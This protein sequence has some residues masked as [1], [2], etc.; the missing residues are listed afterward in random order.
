MNIAEIVMPG[1]VPGIHVL[2]A[3]WTGVDGR[4]KPSHDAAETDGAHSHISYA[5]ALPLAGRGLEMTAAS[6][7][8]IASAAT[9]S[10]TY[11]RRQ[12]G[13]L[14]YARN[15]GDRASV[16]PLN[17]VAETTPRTPYTSDREWLRASI[18]TSP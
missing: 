6:S 10:R 14:R 18:L 13:L 9:Q 16:P 15:D 5:I 7:S 1:L 17:E 2:C 4:D 12:S 3:A 11:P 8:V